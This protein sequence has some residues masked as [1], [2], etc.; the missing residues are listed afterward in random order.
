V[1]A[2]LAGMVLH[3]HG[4]PHW[5]LA[6]LPLTPLA[7]GINIAVARWRTRPLSE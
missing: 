7:I 5:Y 1:F 4:T 2:T 3:P 6:F